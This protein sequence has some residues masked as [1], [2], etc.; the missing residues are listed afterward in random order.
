MITTG[1]GTPILTC[2]FVL[3]SWLESHG[4]FPSGRRWESL[5]QT[6]W[7]RMEMADFPAVI[8]HLVLDVVQMFQIPCNCFSL[9][10]TLRKQHSVNYGFL[11]VFLTYSSGTDVNTK[12]FCLCFLCLRWGASGPWAAPSF[13]VLYITTVC[14]FYVSEMGGSNGREHWGT[15]SH[16]KEMPLCTMD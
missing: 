1:T 16:G 9:S 2:L 13:L 12:E 11:A 8:S 7:E 3:A 4:D 15:R 14:V 10:P 6:C 5:G